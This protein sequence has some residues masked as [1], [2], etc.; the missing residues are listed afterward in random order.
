MADSPGSRD[1]T[2]SSRR[3]VLKTL[4]AASMVGIAGCS[5]GDGGSPTSTPDP[6]GDG[7]D[8]GTTGTPAS[9]EWP[10]LS[11]TEVHFLYGQPSEEA[12][13]YF[14][15]IGAD[16]EDATGA[17]MNMEFTGIDNLQSRVTQLLQSNDPPELAQS[18]SQFAPTYATQG[19]LRPITGVIETLIERY[20]DM[21][22]GARQ[23]YDGEDRYMPL[24]ANPQVFFYR[25]DLSDTVPDTWDNLLAYAEEV[26]QSDEVD[27]GNY[28]P[29]GTGS[30]AFW[31]TVSFAYTNDVKIVE[32][33]NGDVVSALDQG[34]NRSR[35]IE[36]LEFFRNRYQYSPAATD[37]SWSGAL[38][39]I[40]QGVAGSSWY[41][42][43]RIINEV[44]RQ[45]SPF[46]EA[47]DITWPEGRSR[48]FT[49]GT[50][51]FVSF[52]GSNSDAADAFLEF[53]TQPE[54]LA[55]IYWTFSNV[56]NAPVYPGIKESD[57]FQ[58]EL[59]T[60]IEETTWTQER[61]DF[62][63]STAVDEMNFVANDTEE[64]HPYA[65][66]IISSNVLPDMV[67]EVL[68]NDQDPGAAV[69]TYSA[70]LQE[71][72]EDAQG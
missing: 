28:Q 67:A 26:D 20:G 65:G 2:V 36:V 3:T 57:T 6:S 72:L 59:E 13:Q 12:Q 16:F 45:N 64:P 38:N 66:T 49:G 41:G 1:S 30:H 50:D 34:Q 46:A 7:G 10:D 19:I 18:N 53:M 61:V 35:W 39:S 27:H 48:T 32:R 42:G 69:D 52:Q 29:A 40:P 33:Q 14:R 71:I 70:E 11:G 25:N 5:S 62:Y 54:Y 24:W 17:T 68:V 9:G 60:L 4:G 31:H 15:G 44:N 58:Q 47:V 43:A 51:G 23:V 21:T 63:Q 8:G 22:T 55:P 56:H 37:S